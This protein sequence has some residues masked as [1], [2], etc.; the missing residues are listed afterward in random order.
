MTKDNLTIQS[1]VIKPHL[2][3]DIDPFDRLVDNRD[4]I[5]DILSDP[6]VISVI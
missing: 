3:S 6:E 2:L 4:H 5:D 1:I